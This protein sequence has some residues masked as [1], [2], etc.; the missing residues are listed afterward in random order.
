M[1]PGTYQ[2]MHPAARLSEAEKEALIAGLIA[3]V[4]QSQD[5]RPAE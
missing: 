1:P 5:A 2:L 3:T 4:K